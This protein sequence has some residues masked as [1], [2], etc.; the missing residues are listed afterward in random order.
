MAR[1][2]LRG[3]EAAAAGMSVAATAAIAPERMALWSPHGDRSFDALNA[4][5][6]QL[7]RALRKAG[8]APGDAVALVCANRPEFVEVLAAC[9]RG[10][11]RI[12]PIN[13]HLTGEEIG[14]IVDDCEAKA[15]FA[16]ARFAGACAEGASQAPA[17]KHR[18]AIAGAI[19]GFEDYESFL[20]GEDADDLTD[21]VLGGSMLYTSGTTGRPKGVYRKKAGVS[22]LTAPMLA[23][24]SFDA[25]RDQALCTGPLY[26]A[27]PLALNLQFPLAAGV[28]V[29]LMDKWDAH[30]TL[31]LIQ[32]HG[33]T[34]T[35]MVPTMFHRLLQL[36][37]DVR[38]A[39]DTRSL[40]WVLHGA[41]PCPVHVKKS[42]IDWLGPVLF[43][44]YAATEGGAFF[45]GSEEWLKKPGSVGS[46][47][48]AEG[49]R[50]VSEAGEDVAEGEIGTVYFKA[51][52]VGRFEYFKA[53]EKT[54]S[55][56]LDDHFT[57]GDMG[58]VDEDGYLFLT[59]RS[60]ELILSGGV[61]VYPAEVDAALLMHDAVA[62][63]CT[64]G[65][66][67]EEWGEEVRS[68][69]QP[70]AGVEPSDALAAELL[71][72]ARAHLAGYKC[73][74]RIDFADDLPRLDSGK[75]QRRKVRD[76]Y[77]QG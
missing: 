46:T 51:P 21:P 68:V 63:V 55:A 4:R 45:I 71:A 26:H 61:N 70:A 40:R 49:V 53:R 35:H 7:A 65:I 16:D 23:S 48:L 31:A 19:P 37:D 6:N 43:E 8:L 52:Q 2:S 9:Q 47:S 69:V 54:A 72:H 42:M 11:F 59:G 15:L 60:A 20:E 30:G 33:I 25:D 1:T 5:A 58:Y 13:W 39:V 38:G 64:V 14:Y 34:H 44:Y 67:D 3:P 28:G 77:L 75:I 50:L 18:F 74:R 22:R 66:P 73:P 36:A 12:T 57:M 24:A 17:C 76:R 10:G 27:A 29:R 56:Y 62:D 41:A 32:D